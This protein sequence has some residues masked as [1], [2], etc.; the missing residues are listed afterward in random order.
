[1][2]YSERLMVRVTP[3]M[4]SAL[5]GVGNQQEF[6]RRAID[7]ALSGSRDA[8]R[9]SSVGAAGVARMKGPGRKISR[10]NVKSESE[11]S[12]NGRVLLSAIRKRGVYYRRE[13][14]KDFGWSEGDLLRVALELRGVIES[15]PV[16]FWI[17]DAA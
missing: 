6:V 17:A 10:K 15:D 9:L 7:V 4:K 8:E 12:T 16:S 2:S 5:S 14:M 3:E 11:L 13:A 1:M